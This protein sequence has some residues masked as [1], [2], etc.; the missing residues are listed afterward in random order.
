MEALS[1]FRTWGAVVGL[2]FDFVGAILVYVGVRMSL[3]DA[4]AL[5]KPVVEMTINDLGSPET[6]AAA[7]AASEGRARER[8]RAGRWAFAGLL[9]FLLGFLLQAIGSW[10]KA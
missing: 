6:V 9:L 2:G 4:L 8:V 10:P 3:I 1:F 5:E 7:H